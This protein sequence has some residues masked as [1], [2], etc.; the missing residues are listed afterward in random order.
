MKRFAS[1]LPPRPGDCH[2]GDFGRLLIVAG[3]RGMS[4]A[5]VLAA[6][7]ALRAGAG[8]V[9][10]C[11]PAEIQPIVASCVPEALT[12]V[13]GEGLGSCSVLAVGPGLG[14]GPEAAKAVLEALRLRVPAVVDADA[15]NV[16]SSLPPGEA[17]EIIRLRGAATVLTPHPGEAGR[18]LGSSADRVQAGRR[19]S[20]ER[21]AEEFGC[22]CLLKGRGTIVCRGSEFYQNS[23]GN[24]GLAKGGSG[25][26]L[27]GLI[28]GLWAQR[29]E[30][31][32]FEA[33]ALGACLHGLAAD[34]AVRAKGER[35]LLAGD[36]IEALP[37]AFR[38]AGL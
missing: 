23:T 37:A 21:I 35:G 31:G 1:F 18:L 36:V 30:T 9:N 19:G 10:A 32:G 26:V 2:K 33:A 12:S 25:D 38:E 16:L 4:G 13:L 34:V 22:V 20:A 28:A 11:V 27:T 29:P 5:A 14:T 7:A 24:P 6:R 17:R 8:L 3:S 15:L